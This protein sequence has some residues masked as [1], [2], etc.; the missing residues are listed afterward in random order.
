MLRV[1]YFQRRRRPNANFSLE[2][3]FDDVRNRL[4]SEVDARV[5]TAPCYSNGFSRRVAIAA[6][7]AVQQGEINHITGDITF[8]AI[9]LS[10]GRTVLTMLD[11]GSVLHSSGLKRLLLQKVWLELPV[12]RSA[13]VTTI[14]QQA[15]SEIVALT[16]CDPA[17]VVVIP[18]AISEQFQ[19]TP[20]EF[21]RECPRILAIGTAPNKNLD[22]LISAIEGLP[23]TL[24]II[25][26]LQEE[27]RQA[28]LQRQIR[29]ENYF[30]LTSEAVIEQYRRSDL[31]SFVSTYEGFGMPILEAQA[32]GRPVITSNLSSMP[33]VAGDA[34][35]L[36][37]P[38]SVSSIRSGLDR[39]IEDKGF[40][41]Q[42]IARGRENVKRF[43]PE[44]IARQ[45]LEVYRTLAR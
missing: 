4:R 10:K 9:P 1:H 29:Y 41:E 25:G 38:L 30:N 24:V 26:Q 23:C 28:L 5:V 12:A 21:N 22:R 34:A 7:A 20:Q 45:Y 37:D 8:V 35:C 11:C 3:I 14:S 17:K 43:D 36:V 13:V 15:K 19:F 42:L 44:R 32:V 16:G 39:V 18:V 27:H 2:F 33:E 40:R 6:H 31:V